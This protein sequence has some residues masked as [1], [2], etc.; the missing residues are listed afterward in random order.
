LIFFSLI[1]LFIMINQLFIAF[2]YIMIIPVFAIDNLYWMIKIQ[3]Q[4]NISEH[5]QLKPYL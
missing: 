3:Q 4:S 2:I 1:A 5:I